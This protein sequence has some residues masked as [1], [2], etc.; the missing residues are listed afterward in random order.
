[1]AYKMPSCIWRTP[2][3]AGQISNK[4]K[5]NNIKYDKINIIDI[6]NDNT[7]NLYYNL[8]NNNDWYIK[9]TL[10]SKLKRVANLGYHKF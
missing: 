3:S 8:L 7:F 10:K 5:N 9:V 4:N 1:M 6:I 2:L